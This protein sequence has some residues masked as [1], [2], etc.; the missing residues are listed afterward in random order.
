[1]GSRFNVLVVE[2][3]PAIVE[4]MIAML[5]SQYNVSSANTVEEALAFLRTSHVDV[6][7]A[8]KVLPDGRASDVARLAEDVGAAVIEMSGYAQDQDGLERSE[9]PYL[10]KPF[11]M[12]TLLSTIGSALHNHLDSSAN[13]RPGAGEP[14]RVPRGPNYT[15]T[16]NP[17]WLDRWHDD[18]PGVL[19]T[20]G[21]ARPHRRTQLED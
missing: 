18:P 20:E 5:E 6:V 15:S 4:V 21:D 8:D 14:F 1:M 12:E 9:R 13:S 3:D 16:A 17:R 2:D 10:N 7:L 19:E 11:G